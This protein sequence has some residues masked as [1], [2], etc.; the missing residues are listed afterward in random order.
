MSE[1]ALKI[2]KLGNGIVTGPIAY[3][4]LVPDCPSDDAIVHISCTMCHPKCFLGFDLPESKIE[5][6]DG[7]RRKEYRMPGLLI[8][9]HD[10]EYSGPP[11]VHREING[12]IDIWTRFPIEECYYDMDGTFHMTD[13][14]TEALNTRTMS[15]YMV[16]LDCAHQWRKLGFIVNCTEYDSDCV[17]SPEL[18][19]Q[20][21][22]EPDVTHILFKD[23]TVDDSLLDAFRGRN[24]SFV[25]CHL[26]A[27][28]CPDDDFEDC[29]FVRLRV[30]RGYY[31][32]NPTSNS[33]SYPKTDVTLST[34]APLS[35]TLV[36]DMITDDIFEPLYDMRR[37]FRDEQGA[38][39]MDFLAA[40]EGPVPDAHIRWIREAMYADHYSPALAKL[41]ST[42][43]LLAEKT[44]DDTWQCVVAHVG[45]DFCVPME[46]I[47]SLNVLIMLTL[48]RMVRSKYMYYTNYVEHD[49]YW[50]REMLERDQIGPSLYGNYIPTFAC[51]MYSKYKDV[52]AAAPMR[53]C[54]PIGP[55][56][57]D[58]FVLD[59]DLDGISD[60]IDR[61]GYTPE[62]L[63]FLRDQL[64]IDH[65]HDHAL[66]RMLRARP[67]V[68]S[69]DLRL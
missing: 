46:W 14:C 64:E 31:V 52:F 16:R 2:A 23:M 32:H 33:M 55:N 50:L 53:K 60:M 42:N 34:F 45:P 8:V 56:I 49:D 39:F 26:T 37:A 6:Y 12:N 36:N 38:M 48:K 22:A 5:F 19:D 43:K 28:Y 59:L 62:I 66:A 63:E 65:M 67:D 58:G 30:P 11:I 7:M 27:T 13:K 4:R 41:L 18:H 40:F 20:I 54:H 44:N 68:A 10:S 61:D 1:F 35:T 9:N 69:S 51:A 17:Y 24:F 57:Y 25:R 29:T 47:H 3:R 15:V 21:L